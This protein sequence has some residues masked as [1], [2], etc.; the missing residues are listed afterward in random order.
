[1]PVYRALATAE[2]VAANDDD[3]VHLV[4][5]RYRQGLFSLVDLYEVTEDWRTVEVDPS[6]GIA[7]HGS[8]DS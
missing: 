4:Q 5:S 6:T 1:M 8:A 3:A 7:H 2:F